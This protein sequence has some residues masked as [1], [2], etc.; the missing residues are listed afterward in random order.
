MPK[1]KKDLPTFSKEGQSPGNPEKSRNISS[2]KKD[3]GADPQTRPNHVKKNICCHLG[4]L[5]NG[6]RKKLQIKRRGVRG[7]NEQIEGQTGKL[8]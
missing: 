4:R 8:K 7:V 3:K 2:S 1:R 6:G 5:V